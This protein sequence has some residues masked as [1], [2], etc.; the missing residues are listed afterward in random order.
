MYQGISRQKAK[1]IIKHSRFK[2]NGKAIP[3]HPALDVEANLWIEK[4]DKHEVPKIHLKPDRRKPVAIHY[5]DRFFLIAI[6]PAGILTHPDSNQPGAKSF[7]KILEAYLSKRDL[8]N[9][10]LWIVHRLD[11]EVEGFLIMAKSEEI[12]E[13]FK[14]NWSTVTKQYLALT[15]GKPE[16]EEGVLESYLRDE[17]HQKVK[18]YPTEVAGSRYAKTSY[19]WIKDALPY[20]VLEVTLHTGRKHQ[21][22]VHLSEL[23]CPIVGDRKYG[24]EPFFRR[25]I[26]LAAYK[27]KLEHPVNQK[28]IELHYQPSARFFKP[29]P[30]AD[31]NYKII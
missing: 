20:S 4:A 27:L 26:R 30:N 13:Q 7:Q 21:I 6:K 2:L 19:R 25:Q 11:R 1:Q 24:A 8:R 14:E 28:I 31:E 18:A 12:A 10:R 5:E 22:R 3:S 29:S 9:T 15:E 23:G 17:E 16:K